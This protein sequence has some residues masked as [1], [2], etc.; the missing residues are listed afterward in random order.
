MLDERRPDLG[1][2]TVHDVEDAWRQGPRRR[3]A[4]SDAESG[5]CSEGFRTAALPQKTAGNTFQA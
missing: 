4:K 5:V 1:A 2:E 3:C